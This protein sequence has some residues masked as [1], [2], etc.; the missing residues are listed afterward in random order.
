MAPVSDW[1]TYGVCGCGRSYYAPFGSRFHIHAEVCGDCGASKETFKM[2]VRR[3]VSTGQ[4]FKPK[5]WGSGHWETQQEPNP[6]ST[7]NP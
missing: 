4:L 5:T 6:R 2:Q 1:N 7:P 3:W